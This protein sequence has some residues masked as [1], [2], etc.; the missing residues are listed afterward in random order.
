MKLKP[1][2]VLA[3]LSI[4]IAGSS[5]KQRKAIYIVVDGIPADYIERLHTPVIFDIASKGHYSRAYT[6]GDK[7]GYSLT[8]TVSAIGYTNILTGTYL[9]LIRLYIVLSMS[10]S[11]MVYGSYLPLSFL[12]YNF[13]S[14][15]F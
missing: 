12:I 1:L 3:L 14:F 7:N 13:G 6:G 4:A 5:A 2:L 10:C 15:I 11:G 8:P 9:P